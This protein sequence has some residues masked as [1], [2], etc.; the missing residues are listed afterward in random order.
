MDVIIKSIRIDNENKNIN[1]IVSDTIEDIITTIEY[2]YGNGDNNK[3][4]VTFDDFIDVIYIPSIYDDNYYFHRKDIW[5]NNF[6]YYNFRLM[7]KNEI[8]KTIREQN[9]NHNIKMNAKEAIAY[10]Y[11]P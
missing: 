1:N 4:H 3:K 2:E 9:S 11:Q 10:L 6:E 7:A 8:I 5:W